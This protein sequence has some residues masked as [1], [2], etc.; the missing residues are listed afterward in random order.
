MQRA[1]KAEL[2]MLREL[3]WFWG[4]RDTCEF[5]KKPLIKTPYDLTFG[6]RRHP[7]IVAK[8]T[9]HHRNRNREDNSIYNTTSC[10][11]ACHRNYHANLRRT[12]DPPDSPDS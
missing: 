7:P 1:T 6:H 8:L 10:H 9:I 3:V 11:Q 12:S 4:T 5:C 2:Q